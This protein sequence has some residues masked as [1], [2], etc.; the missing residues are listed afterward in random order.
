MKGREQSP[1]NSP[2]LRYIEHLTSHACR[3]FLQRGANVVIVVVYLKIERTNLILFLFV[4]STVTLIM[5]SVIQVRECFF[6]SYQ[7][8]NAIKY[9][10][11]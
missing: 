11:H 5:L 2:I 9:L 6:S 7:L 8:H 1:R 10:Y 3:R 4:L